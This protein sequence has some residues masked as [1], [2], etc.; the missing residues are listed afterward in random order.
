M[1]ATVPG[2]RVAIVCRS[3][4]AALQATY[5]FAEHLG[6]EAVT[7]GEVEGSFLE[8]LEGLQGAG[9]AVIVM[10]PG[11]SPGELLLETGF[12]LAAPGPSRMC[13]LLADGAQ[14]GPELQDLPR[15]AMDGGGLWRLLLAR[16]M[17]R[18]GLNV[19]LNRAI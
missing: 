1:S 10:G 4:D 11:A 2:S 16:E 8:R 15:Y 7:A 17:R 19:D 3:G 9:F 18:A 6:L 5:A 13:L 14:P 12:L